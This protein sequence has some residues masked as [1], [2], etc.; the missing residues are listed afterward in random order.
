ESLPDYM[1]PA[2]FV[3]LPSFPQTPNNKVDRKA[4]PKPE[5]ESFSDDLSASYARNDFDRALVSVWRRILARTAVSIDDDFFAMGGDSMSAITLIKEMKVATGVE[6]PLSSIFEAPTI[7]LLTADAGDV[8]S[9]NASVVSL[10]KVD[11]SVD[12]VM[13]CLAGVEIYRPLAE[14]FSDIP[15]Y[16]AYAKQEINI[17]E[18]QASGASKLTINGLVDAYIEAITRQDAS[19]NIILAGLSFG[20]L[21]ALEVAVQL[22]ARGYNV[23]HIV[24]LDTRL[25]NQKTR[26]F[27]KIVPD[28]I[29]LCRRQGVVNVAN[30]LLNKVIKPK[31]VSATVNLKRPNPQGAALRVLTQMYN[32][33]EHN[34]PFD[35]LLVKASSEQV[36]IGYELK[37]DYG[38][39]KIVKGSIEVAEIA[40]THTGIVHGGAVD[41]LYELMSKYFSR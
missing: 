22:V 33:D 38:F 26:R 14:K 23:K 12:C 27:R 1:I 8:S 28:I 2:H 5:L 4:L 34:Y 41:K 7:R 25:P 37:H 36:G 21:L 30:R 11:A 15:V 39:S 19:K 31:Q 35:V 32:V 29:K 17:I 13:Y 16:G 20:G 10:N 9:K 40:A 3:C 24:L 18:H 6:F